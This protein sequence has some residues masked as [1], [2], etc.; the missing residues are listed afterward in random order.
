ML[1][2]LLPRS[3]GRLVNRHEPPRGR[4]TDALRDWIDS[5]A[6]TAEISAQSLAA[7]RQV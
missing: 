7:A 2:R 1:N 3:A 5:G 4:F 6:S